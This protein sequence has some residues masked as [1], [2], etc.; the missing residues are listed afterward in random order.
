MTAVRGL[1]QASQI[2]FCGQWNR[3]KA[4]APSFC[5]QW[6]RE[7][8]PH[9]GTPAGEINMSL[10]A[11][12]TST[13]PSF[14]V[15]GHSITLGINYAFNVIKRRNVLHRAIPYANVQIFLGPTLD[16]NKPLHISSPRELAPSLGSPSEVF[17]HYYIESQKIYN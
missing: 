10:I 4:R 6:N 12:L 9:V 15:L 3:K 5:G 17:T 13:H 8:L 7:A 14:Y 11:L 16:R 1:C 2:R